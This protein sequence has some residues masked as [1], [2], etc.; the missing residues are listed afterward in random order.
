M[1]TRVVF[2]W[3]VAVAVAGAMVGAS[4]AHASSGAP[5]HAEAA[6][7]GGADALNPLTSFKRDTA[8]FTAVVFGLLMWILW[9]F[10]WGPIADGLD[11]R[12]QRIA[13]EIAA[14]EKANVDA[15]QLLADYQAKLASSEAKVREILDQG[16][17]DAEQ[18]GCELVEKA[19]AEAD[20]E[21]QR[22]LREIETATAG[23]LK[24]LAER[25]AT[26]AI[27]LAGKILR[28]RLDPKQHA[29]LIDEAV[30]RFAGSKRNGN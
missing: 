6:G 23:A 22:A 13:G 19:R 30:S 26:L 18:A 3:L 7:D 1:S 25:S 27:E 5:A 8:L 9:K 29:R 14:A 11:K 24:E 2:A 10:A 4:A 20:I 15:K 17:R 12:E 21:R 28:Q 16:R